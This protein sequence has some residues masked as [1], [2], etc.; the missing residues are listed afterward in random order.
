MIQLSKW[1]T[2]QITQ[3]IDPNMTDMTRSIVEA[4]RCIG[5]WIMA[6]QWIFKQSSSSTLALV[7]RAIVFTLSQRSPI[8]E[9]KKEE[10]KRKTAFL[11]TVWTPNETIKVEKCEYWF[12][13]LKFLFL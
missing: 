9:E 3:F 13:L 1:V 8:S 4:L 5:D 2:N 6:G 7:I 12:F 11:P 10:D